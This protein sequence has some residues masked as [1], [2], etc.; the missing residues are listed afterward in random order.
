MSPGLDGLLSQPPIGTLHSPRYQ[1]AAALE[2]HFA[3]RGRPGCLPG[4]LAE[5]KA[6]LR[7]PVP[8]PDPLVATSRGTEG[9]F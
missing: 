4:G 7:A 9:G 2:M 1:K 5:G 3:S 6:S 8:H